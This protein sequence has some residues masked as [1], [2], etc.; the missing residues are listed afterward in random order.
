MK[1]Q[2]PYESTGSAIK[3]YSDSVTARRETNDCVVRAFASAFDVTYDYAHKYVAEQFGRKPRKGTYYTASKI[4]KL[5]E[6]VLKVNDKKIIPVGTKSNSVVYPYSL[7]YE[8]KVKG[9]VVKR[10]MTV[11]T[12]VKKNPKGTFF[13][14]VKGHAFTI[15]DGVVIG[16]PEDAIKTKRPMRSAFQ[17]K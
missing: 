15:K 7:S 14:L 11:G 1:N 16:N 17:I 2:L 3:G 4:T 10:Q 6:G 12:F 8:V 5:S 9:D 13:V